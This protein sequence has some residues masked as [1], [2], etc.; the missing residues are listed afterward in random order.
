MHKKVILKK[1]DDTT[2]IDDLQN[3]I[4]ELIQIGEDYLKNDNEFFYI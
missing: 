3:R 1:M 2:T 4:D